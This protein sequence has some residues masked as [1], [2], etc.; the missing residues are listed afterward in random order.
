MCAHVCVTY[1]T[2]IQELA[3]QTAILQTQYP[4]KSFEKGSLMNNR[5]S[6]ALRKFKHP[7]VGS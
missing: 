4:A 5:P 7:A 1:L 2:T 6:G 3:P